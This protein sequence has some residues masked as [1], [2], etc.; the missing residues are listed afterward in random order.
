MDQQSEIKVKVAFKLVLIKPCNSKNKEKLRRMINCIFIRYTELFFFK[1]NDRSSILSCPF[2]QSS[3]F[4]IIN[5]I[6]MYSVIL[7]S[8]LYLTHTKFT[9]YYCYKIKRNVH[10]DQNSAVLLLYEINFIGYI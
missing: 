2:H 5:V 8:R 7:D 4:S 3:L 6:N 10:T 9:I 1:L